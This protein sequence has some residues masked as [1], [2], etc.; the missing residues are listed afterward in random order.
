MLNTKIAYKKVLKKYS[1]GKEELFCFVVFN[2]FS[3][4]NRDGSVVKGLHG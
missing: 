3:V 2:L 4:G 1:K